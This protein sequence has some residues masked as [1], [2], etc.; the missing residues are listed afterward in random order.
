M[1]EMISIIENGHVSGL[2]IAF[3]VIS[4][5]MSIVIPVVGALYLR[6]KYDCK[7]KAFLCGALIWLLFASILESVVHQIVLGSEAGATIQGNIWLYGLYGGF[8]AALFEETGRFVGFKFFMKGPKRNNMNALMY[9]LG[10]GGFEAIYI[11]G[12]GMFSN[13]ACAFMINSG[14]I[15]TTI[16]LMVASGANETSLQGLVQIVTAAPYIF[17]LGLFERIAAMAAHIAMSVPVWFAVRNKKPVLLALSFGM[18]FSL[19]FVSAV[20]A[21]YISNLILVEVIIYIVAIAFVFI[22]YNVYKANNIPVEEE[23][24]AEPEKLIKKE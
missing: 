3:M 11:L 1:E 19:D 4:A 14:T 2:S 18:H 8:M 24:V 17:I 12:L 6:K 16:D 9:G 10:H 7:I 21:H 20:A 22:A 23:P 5:I 15:S 13:L